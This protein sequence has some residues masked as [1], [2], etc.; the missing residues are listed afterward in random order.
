MLKLKTTRR[1]FF[2]GGVAALAMI[3]AGAKGAL[4]KVASGKATGDGSG[5]FPPKADAVLNQQNDYEI[6]MAIPTAWE[7]SAAQDGRLIL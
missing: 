4:A 2:T 1:A 7:A 5:G 6:A 3:G